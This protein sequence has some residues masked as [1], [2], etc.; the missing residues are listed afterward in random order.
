[1]IQVK[2]ETLEEFKRTWVAIAHE[3]ERDGIQSYC[4][5]ICGAY[6]NCGTER[7]CQLGVDEQTEMLAAPELIDDDLWRHLISEW[8]Q[9][10]IVLV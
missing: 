4:Q 3:I 8:L 5:Q 7:V 2:K 10:D 9:D 1:M 6:K